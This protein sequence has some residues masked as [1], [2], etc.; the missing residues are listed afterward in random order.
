MPDE[1]N[2]FK[3]L[4]SFPLLSSEWPLFICRESTY[5]EWLIDQSHEIVVKE[6]L[7]HYIITHGNSILDIIGYQDAEVVCSLGFVIPD[8]Q[9]HVMEDVL[10]FVLRQ[11][12]E[13]IQW[14]KVYSNIK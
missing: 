13:F 5:V 4:D 6:G 3:R 1:T 11:C 10:L 12:F 7:C 2:I 9:I 14:A 8:H